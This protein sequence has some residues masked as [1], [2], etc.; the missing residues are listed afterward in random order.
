MNSSL[1]Y[2][3]GNSFAW[4][5]IHNLTV[6]LAGF[7]GATHNRVACWNLF[8]ILCGIDVWSAEGARA[9]NLTEM[10]CIKRAYQ[11]CWCDKGCV[12]A[13]LDDAPV[14]SIDHVG[15]RTHLNYVSTALDEIRHDSCTQCRLHRVLSRE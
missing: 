9:R 5:R 15:Y 14:P 11:I 8:A 2:L 7:C 4:I 13:G 3:Q 12:P 1:R 10:K 6:Y